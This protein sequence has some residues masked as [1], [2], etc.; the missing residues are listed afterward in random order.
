[1][2]F[3]KQ[4]SFRKLENHV[5]GLICLAIR[6]VYWLTFI[7]GIFFIYTSNSPSVFNQSNLLMFSVSSNSLPSV[8]NQSNLLMFSVSS[9]S[10]PSV[11]NQSNLFMFGVSSNSLPS[12]FNQTNLF[13][14]SV[15]SNSLPS[16][17]NQS[18]LECQV[19]LF[20][21]WIYFQKNHYPT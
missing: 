13:M 18:N 20:K 11:F 1:M 3:F 9:N 15:S 7:Y 14:F 19:G 21:T 16:V 12:V 4:K 10:L 17:F 6:L 5:L 2:I 8:F